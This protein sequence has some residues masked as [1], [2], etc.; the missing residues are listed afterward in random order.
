LDTCCVTRGLWKIGCNYFVGHFDHLCILL[1]GICGG[2]IVL[3]WTASTLVFDFPPLLY[4]LAIQLLLPVAKHKSWDGFMFSK[5]WE[6]VKGICFFFTKYF[7][8]LL[9]LLNWVPFFLRFLSFWS[10]CADNLVETG[11]C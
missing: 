6:K 4:A 1:Y 9:L 8:F 3:V 2:S 11:F 7:S 5:N 10:F